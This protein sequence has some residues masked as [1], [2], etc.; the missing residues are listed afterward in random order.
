VPLKGRTFASVSLTPAR[1]HGPHLNDIY[2]G[3]D[4]QQYSFDTL[5]GVALTGDF[6][7]AVVF[8]LALRRHAHLHV[9]VQHA[10][11]RLVIDA[12]R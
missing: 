3:P 2:V 1:A 5:R 8:G 9:F 11:N 4:L 6:E 10:P 12:R 7:A